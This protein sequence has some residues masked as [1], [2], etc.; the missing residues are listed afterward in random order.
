[1][2]LL[3]YTCNKT[4]TNCCNCTSFP[5]MKISQGL[6]MF[7]HLYTDRNWSF[8]P[9]VVRNLFFVIFI[10]RKSLLNVCP[11]LLFAWLS[12]YVW[13][14]SGKGVQTMVWTS[15]SQFFS[16]CRQGGPYGDEHNGHSWPVTYGDGSVILLNFSS[17]RHADKAADGTW[18]Q[19]ESNNMSDFASYRERP[20]MCSLHVSTP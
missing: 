17:R 2:F 13:S 5:H 8:W 7:Q 11:L 12:V 4:K 10:W 18:L 6:I 16:V 19:C 20:R 14:R 9:W 15:S 1:M 3:F